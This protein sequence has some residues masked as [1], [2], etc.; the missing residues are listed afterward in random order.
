MAVR[1]LS[2]RPLLVVFVAC[3]RLSPRATVARTDEGGSR[4]KGPAG[5][6]VPPMSSLHLEG[7]GRLAFFA[8][9]IHGS[10]ID[11]EARSSCQPVSG[12]TMFCDRPRRRQGAEACG[13]FR[14]EMCIYCTS[15]TSTTLI[16]AQARER[17][18]TPAAAA[19]RCASDDRVST[20]R[21]ARTAVARRP[22]TLASRSVEPAGHVARRQPVL[23][24]ATMVALRNLMITNA[25]M[26]TLRAHI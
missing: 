19:S 5:A 12:A 13:L 2:A 9:H 25:V 11:V 14:G 16:A 18:L 20:N 23:V 3:D 26:N 24:T 1:R 10:T 17:E 6:D 4:L 15:S 7:P 22:N 8:G 21:E